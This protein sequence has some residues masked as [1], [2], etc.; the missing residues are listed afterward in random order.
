VN[1]IAK[2]IRTWRA[3]LRSAKKSGSNATIASA[4]AS[5]YNWASS[6]RRLMDDREHRACRMLAKVT[7]REAL[8]RGCKEFSNG[9]LWWME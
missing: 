7:R 8:A 9:M 4:H 2:D 1:Q 3:L 5:A 6:P